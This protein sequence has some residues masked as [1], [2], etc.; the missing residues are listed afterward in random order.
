MRLPLGV[1]LFRL[2]PT[3]PFLPV[4]YSQLSRTAYLSLTLSQYYFHNLNSYFCVFENYFSRTVKCWK[5]VN[6]RC[7]IWFYWPLQHWQICP[8]HWITTVS[9][10][11]CSRK[12]FWSTLAIFSQKR[13]AHKLS[14]IT[15]TSA[16]PR[17]K[18]NNKSN[19]Y[20]NINETAMKTASASAALKTPSY[21]TCPPRLWQKKGDLPWSGG[22][23]KLTVEQIAI[24]NALRCW[25]CV[26]V[27]DAAVT[28]QVPKP[29]LLSVTKTK[30]HNLLKGLSEERMG[31]WCY[32]NYF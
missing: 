13:T 2:P 1:C 14:Q 28:W 22:V 24:E 18:N 9:V 11:C 20:T 29:V 4:T 3:T 15:T 30:N 21:P 7:L 17:N 5:V 31:K 10:F 8:F 23:V 27:C 32:Y 12:C 26:W 19:C 16:V 25:H 6:E